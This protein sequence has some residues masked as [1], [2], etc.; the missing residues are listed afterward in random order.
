MALKTAVGMAD[1]A[2]SLHAL[3][4]SFPSACRLRDLK[5]ELG[6]WAKQFPQKY[7]ESE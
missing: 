3:S 5:I 2:Y 1:G 6:W 4:R 7:L